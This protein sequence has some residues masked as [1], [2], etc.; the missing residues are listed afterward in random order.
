MR[1]RIA[2]VQMATIHRPCSIGIDLPAGASADDLSPTDYRILEMPD[3]GVEM[4]TIHRP[5]DEVVALPPGTTAEQLM[6]TDFHVVE[7]GPDAT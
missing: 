7:I 4:A 5:N 3:V 1:T 6:T 2:T